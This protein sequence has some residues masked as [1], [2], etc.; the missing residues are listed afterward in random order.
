MTPL[1]PLIQKYIDKDDT[2]LALG[3]GIGNA[4]EG[5]VCK[6]MVGVD[7]FRDYLRHEQIMR[8][9]IPICADVR[10]IRKIF[11]PKSFDVVIA[12]DLIEH[13][14]QIEGYELLKDMETIARKKVVLYTPKIWSDNKSGIKAWG[15]H[16]KL[17]EHKSL[18][19][20]EDFKNLGYDIDYS[21]FEGIIA[22][23]VIK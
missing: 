23:K 5:I 1:T 7:A 22:V 12:L 13:L 16:N 9:C 11:I 18:W 21:Y 20:D 6:T 19:K 15:F 8:I 14:T 17:Q 10:E 3:I 2:V 4:E